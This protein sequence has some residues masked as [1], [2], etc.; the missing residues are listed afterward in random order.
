MINELCNLIG[1]EDFEIKLY[2]Q[3]FSRHCVFTGKYRTRRSSILV[4]LLPGKANTEILQKLSLKKKFR[5]FILFLN[6][7][8]R[9]KFQKKTKN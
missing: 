7:Y 8:H 5:Q 3:N 6:F 2:K 9:A 1:R 4:S